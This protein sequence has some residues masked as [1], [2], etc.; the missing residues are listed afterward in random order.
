MRQRI[1]AGLA[2]AGLMTGMTGALITWAPAASAG[3][4]A[5]WP[6][7]ELCDDP[8]QP[9]GTWQRCIFEHNAFIPTYRKPEGCLTLGNTNPLPFGE[10]P[11][12]I[13]P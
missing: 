8:I 12:H 4:A 11:G 9:D 5:G 6:G 10:P 2:A 13:G 1:V 7:T 3:C